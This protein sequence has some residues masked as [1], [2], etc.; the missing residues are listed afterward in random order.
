MKQLL[1]HQRQRPLLDA[2]LL[3]LRTIEEELANTITHGLGLLLSI[4]GLVGL[5]IMLGNMS[6]PD[7]L[8][9]SMAVALL[10]TLYGSLLAN[11]IA[12]HL[13]DKLAT[14]SRE[15]LMLKEI[16]IKGVMAI[17]SGDNPRVVEQKL[18][19]FL[20]HRVRQAAGDERKA[21]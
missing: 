12:L 11:R 13:A 10:T 14:R 4:A 16:V 3:T 1:E 17:Q 21:A 8:G 5:V 19:S 6:D 15:E 7:S 20:P 9:P 2:E 18:K